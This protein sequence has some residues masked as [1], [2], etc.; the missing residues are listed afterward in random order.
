MGSFVHL[1]VHSSYSVLDGMS[2]ISGLVDKAIASNMHAIALT[3]HG[4]MFGIKEFFNYSKKINGKIKGQI[5]DLEKELASE[6][7]T[8]ERRN[9]ITDEIISKKEKIFK[10]IFGS[11]V[12]VARRSRFD[13]EL[14]EDRSGYHLVLLAKN[15]KGYKNDSW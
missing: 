15:K 5:K 12:Y 7:I 10:P 14:K 13:K 2:S 4:N 3:D 9:A 11:E 6:G 8:D 1:H